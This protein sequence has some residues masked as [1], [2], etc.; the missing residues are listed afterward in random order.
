MIDKL[1]HIVAF[2]ITFVSNVSVS[3]GVVRAGY[4]DTAE[5]IAYITI[6]LI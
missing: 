6:N 5:F 1:L 2:P 4:T 3:K